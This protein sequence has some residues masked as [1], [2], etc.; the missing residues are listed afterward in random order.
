MATR[1]LNELIEMADTALYQSKTEGRNR[2]TMYSK[3][4]ENAVKTKNATPE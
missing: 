4:E 1:D 2:T 3:N